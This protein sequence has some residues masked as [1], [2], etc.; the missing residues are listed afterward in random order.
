MEYKYTT[1]K[2]NKNRNMSSLRVTKK[3][4]NTL[5]IRL[6]IEYSRTKEKVHCT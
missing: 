5:E 4:T 3:I 1:L 6:L 2:K